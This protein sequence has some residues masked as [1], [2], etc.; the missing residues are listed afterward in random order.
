MR[1]ISPSCLVWLAS[2]ALAGTSGA[3]P[4]FVEFGQSADGGVI[5]PTD[6]SGDGSTVV[7][8]SQQAYRWDGGVVTGLGYLPGGGTYSKAY[9]ISADGSTIVGQSDREDG[10]IEA[11][12]WSG[13]TIAGLGGLDGGAV[14]DGQANG[15]SADGSVIVGVV[16]G[17]SGYEAF[18]WT[19]ESRMVGLGD[20]PGGTFNSGAQAISDDGSTIVG[21]AH[22]AAGAEPYRWANGV[23]TGLGYLPGGTSF[24]FASAVS[25]DGSVIVGVSNSASGLQAFRW[26][27]GSGMIGLGY[28]AGGGS[29]SA[30]DAVS[31]DGSVIVG[32]SGDGNPFFSTAFIWDEAHGMRNLQ[33]VLEGLG[34]DLTGWTLTEATSISPDGT[35]ITGFAE[36]GPVETQSWIAT[37]PKPPTSAC[38]DGIDNDGDGLLDYPADPGC[39]TPTSMTESPACDDG[40]DNDGDGKIDFD[41]GASANHGVALGLPD[42]QCTQPYR[43]NE[44]QQQACGLG[45]E[46]VIPL[47]ALVGLVR[48]KASRRGA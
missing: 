15:V 39:F 29:Q 46:L 33:S 47:V 41:G 2:F 18:R 38:N 13:G 23:M 9:G 30:A 20:L 31:A 37:L 4:S 32:W 24:G 8:G 26:T 36:H 22:S 25:A 48:R 43:I 6:V 40:I 11:A 34:L 14:T 12:R 7:G 35:V 16:N 21:E 3:A 10:V 17:P 44:R 5:W 28:L 45:A 19:A 1:R 42:P 27:A